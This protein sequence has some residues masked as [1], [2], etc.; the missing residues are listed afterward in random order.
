M[1]NIPTTNASLASR[2][3]DD[4]I[5]EYAENEAEKRKPVLNYD[6]YKTADEA[7]R[8]FI[9]FCGKYKCKNCRFGDRFKPAGCAI[10]WLY[11]EA[12]GESNGSK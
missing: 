1:A 11:D 2:M 5:G 6:R 10:A 7:Y 3:T 12:K 4:E 9:E 8:A